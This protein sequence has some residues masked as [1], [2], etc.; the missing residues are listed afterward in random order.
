MFYCYIIQT[1]VNTNTALTRRLDVDNNTDEGLTLNELL[2]MLIKKWWIIV[3]FFIVGVTVSIIYAYMFND[4]Y[5]EA[6]SSMIVQVTNTYD[7]DYT[8]LL[9]G[10]KLINTYSEIAS[11]H[12]AI[13]TLKENLNLNL[14]QSQIKDMI[15]VKGISDTLI[16]KLSVRSFDKQL[17]ADMANELIL[18]V[19]GLSQQ[20]EGLESVEILDP[21]LIPTTPAGPNRTLYIVIGALLSGILGCSIV[22]VFE[23]FSNKIRS[24]SDIKIHLGIKTLGRI[25]FHASKN[26]NF[27]YSLITKDDPHSFESIQYRKLRTNIDYLSIDKTYKSINITSTSAEEGKTTT[28]INLANV[29]A[30]NNVKTLLIDMDIRNPKI[31]KG[32]N[33]SNDSGLCNYQ[34]DSIKIEDFIVK[35]SD[36]LYVLTTGPKFPFPSEFLS[37]QRIKKMIKDLESKYDKIIIDGP[38]ASMFPDS[39]IISNFCSGTLYV[40]LLKKS[41]IDLTKKTLLDLRMSNVDIIGGVLTQIPIKEMEYGK[42]Y[43]YTKYKESKKAEI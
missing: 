37:S 19:K 1:N 30:N 27:E 24:E 16:V 4:D 2:V 17:A 22:F 6:E 3:G 42:E 32:F 34:H 40:L 25:P 29:Y 11:S 28:A 8:D 35:I 12:I 20:F 15:T 10:E 38:P 23:F 21:A 7:S 43:Y 39:K 26:S 33:I 31:H 36:F 9:T 13:E 41:K 18:I 14:S 5:Y